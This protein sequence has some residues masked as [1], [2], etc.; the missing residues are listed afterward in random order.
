MK[1]RIINFSIAMSLVLSS[2]MP[3]G[4]VSASSKNNTAKEEVVYVD[5]DANGK[6]EGIDVVNVFKVKSGDKITDYGNYSNVSNMTTLDDVT[7]QDGKTTFTASSDGKIYYD[8]KTKSNE[9][10]WNIS[11]KYYLDGR[12]KSAEEIAGA[13][14][15]LK[16][17]LKATKNSKYDG[18]DFYKNY[19]LQ[20]SIEF[21]SEKVTNIVADGATIANV[22][23]DKKLT[24]IAL[25][26]E[27]ADYTITADV[28]DFETDG[29]SINGIPLS[30]DIEVDDSELL[31]KVNELQSAIKK[32][33]NGAEK[34]ADGTE[35]IEDGIKTIEKYLKKLNS[36]SSDLNDGSDAF[37]AALQKLQSALNSADFSAVSD[38]TDASD[39]IADA[40][41]QLDEG[42]GTLESSTEYSAYKS[43][44][45]A[46]LK[47]NYGV[48]SDTLASTDQYVK[49]VL[50]FTETYLK[51]VNSGASDLSNGLAELD[52]NY[53]EFN[54]G[55]QELA[56]A[57]TQLSKLKTVIAELVDAYEDL[58]SGTSEYTAAVAKILAGYKELSSGA[59]SL[60]SGANSLSSGTT[61]LRSKTST[62]DTTVSDKIDDLID[63]IKGNADIGSFT[64]D[65]N[66]NVLAVQFVYKTDKIEIAEAEST[67]E[68]T[69]TDAR[70]FWQKLVDLFVK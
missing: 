58:N 22:G 1:T 7:Y 66:T 20:S 55:L 26:N 37:Y 9:S 14:G 16:M 17:T 62:L 40:I 5:L 57:V 63:S 70:S 50:G 51:G 67:E 27:G 32:L 68:T 38:L 48:T 34:V 31:E 60:T 41:E 10:P 54:E 39:Q 69:E 28:T 8:G 2:V 47:Q 52:E 46:Y 11:I 43:T 3:L 36:K 44:L 24:Y 61:K 21:N 42:A 45:D 19:A 15:K 12:E 64:S 33:D 29:F 4:V 18:P 13:S 25:P 35:K 6:V 23:E 53:A 49:L 65:K 30:L 59:S 56:S